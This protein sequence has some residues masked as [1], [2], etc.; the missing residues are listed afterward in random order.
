MS[1]IV[2]VWQWFSAALEMKF[3]CWEKLRCSF[4]QS[5]LMHNICSL[6]LLSM[7]INPP[8]WLIYVL[9][10]TFSQI[11]NPFR[12]Q[13]WFL[14]ILYRL[15]W[16]L[17]WYFHTEHSGVHTVRVW[18]GVSGGTDAVLQGRGWSLFVEELECF[19]CWALVSFSYTSALALASL[20]TDQLHNLLPSPFVSGLRPARTERPSFVCWPATAVRGPTRA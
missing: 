9:L 20:N 10:F 2:C 7:C 14:L 19:C 5:R 4:T 15:N 13:K 6:S 1:F 16:K 8:T 3:M 17:S 18:V 12:M 11:V